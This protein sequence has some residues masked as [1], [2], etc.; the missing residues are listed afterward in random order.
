MNF[1]LLLITLLLFP[2]LSFGEQLMSKNVDYQEAVFA[3][4]CFWCVEAAFDKVDGVIETTSGYTGG[5][6]P[7]PTYEQVSTGTSGHI[8]ALK[9]KYDPKI[10]TY[11]KLLDY[12][13][14]NVDPL[15]PA[16]QFCDK[17]TQYLGVIFYADDLQ[18]QYAEQSLKTVQGVIKGVVTTKILAL[19]EFYP[20]EEYHQGYY[21]KNP[22]RYEMY[23]MACGRDKR[24]KTVWE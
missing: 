12:F 22:V 23:K 4:G 9:V 19:K 17:G 20:A 2:S 10:V 7:N 3:A 14:K 11:E 8:E 21:K 13:W 16:G 18:K 5:Q 1:K 15:D 24:L 6:T